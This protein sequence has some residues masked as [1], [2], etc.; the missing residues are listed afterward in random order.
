ME[1]EFGRGARRSAPQQIIGVVPGE[2][3]GELLDKTEN[4]L[5]DLAEGTRSGRERGQSDMRAGWGRVREG[6][7]IRGPGGAVAPSC[8]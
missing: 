8:I 4:K 5:S 2:E 6:G 7:R 3:V 1:R